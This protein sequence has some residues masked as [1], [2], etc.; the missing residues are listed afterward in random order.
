M[1]ELGL[2]LSSSGREDAVSLG[3]IPP[4]R[5]K[6]QSLMVNCTPPEMSP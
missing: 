4:L 3:V 1:D 2:D 6:H 5:M